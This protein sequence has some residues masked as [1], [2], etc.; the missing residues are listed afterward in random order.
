[1]MSLMSLLFIVIIF[2]LLDPCAYIPKVSA[3][4]G[5]FVVL[6][7]YKYVQVQYYSVGYTSC[8]VQ[9]LE[10]TSSDVL[11]SCTTYS[12]IS[13]CTDERVQYY[14][15]AALLVATVVQKLLYVAALVLHGSILAGI[16]YFREIEVSRTMRTLLNPCVSG[17][18]VLRM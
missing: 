18:K 15:T 7:Q 5:Q 1:M 2:M 17:R 9:V 6:V 10:K 12:T 13:S 4:V 16:Y 8:T 3:V 14:Y 11:S